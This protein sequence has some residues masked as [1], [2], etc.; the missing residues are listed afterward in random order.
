MSVSDNGV[1]D[2]APES[3][4]HGEFDGKRVLVT[5]AHAASGPQ[6]PTICANAAP[7]WRPW[8]VRCPHRTHCFRT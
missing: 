8:P 3:I 5:G 4:P 2:T 1:R 6:S 7:E